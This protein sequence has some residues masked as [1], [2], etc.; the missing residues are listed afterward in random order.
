VRMHR[1]ESKTSEMTV[2]EGEEGAEVV[3]KHCVELASRMWRALSLSV[4]MTG[5]WR[6][7]RGT[8]GIGGRPNAHLHRDK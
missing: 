3:R 6:E 1:N 5:V 4:G 8:M 7:A 2:D